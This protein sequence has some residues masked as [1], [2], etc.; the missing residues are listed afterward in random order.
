MISAM[1]FLVTIVAVRI[2]NRRF[3][4]SGGLAARQRTTALG[5]FAPLMLAPAVRAY[6]LDAQI[7]H[8]LRASFG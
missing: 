2:L 1:S 6:S 8:R 5:A 4:D 3:V 7:R